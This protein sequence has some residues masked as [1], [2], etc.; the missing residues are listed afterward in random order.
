MARQAD[1]LPPSRSFIP[2]PTSEPKADASSKLANARCEVGSAVSVVIATCPP[3]VCGHASCADDL[4]RARAPHPFPV[5]KR[6]KGQSSSPLP[7]SQSVPAL[8][9]IPRFWP[10]LVKQSARCDSTRAPSSHLYQHLCHRLRY[11]LCLL[12]IVLAC[13][14]SRLFLATRP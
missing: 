12:G 6:E 1:P 2:L 4:V 7:S 13:R 14:N 11:R 10:P 9:L 3:K 5:R 8:N